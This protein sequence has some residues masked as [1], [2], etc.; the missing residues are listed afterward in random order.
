MDKQTPD[1]GDHLEL[2][3]MTLAK[4]YGSIESYS[5]GSKCDA[6]FGKLQKHSF[7][8]GVD[9]EA[10]FY[11]APQ[12]PTCYATEIDCQGSRKKSFVIVP[13]KSRYVA[14]TYLFYCKK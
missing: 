3:R 4:A 11:A 14:I 2:F 10:A 9:F 13:S 6:I 7:F 8:A 12:P 1:Q 5:L